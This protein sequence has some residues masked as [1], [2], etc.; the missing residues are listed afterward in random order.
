MRYT[1]E[2]T[3]LRNEVK[4]LKL[5]LR[6]ERAQCDWLDALASHYRDTQNDC[7]EDYQIS[8]ENCNELYKR[9]EELQKKE[10]ENQQKNK[11]LVRL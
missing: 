4:E 11:P 10:R 8:Q 9:F 1:H 2:I 6:I 5:L 3:Q 7:D